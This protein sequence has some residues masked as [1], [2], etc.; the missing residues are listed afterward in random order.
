M[1]LHENKIST[2]QDKYYKT[3]FKNCECMCIH[4]KKIMAFINNVKIVI[5][6][7]RLKAASYPK[8][9]L[10]AGHV[11]FGHS[12]SILRLDSDGSIITN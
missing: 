10:P 1:P 7:G 3:V 11:L 8:N 6:E 5:Q 2:D 9:K 12:C 4:G